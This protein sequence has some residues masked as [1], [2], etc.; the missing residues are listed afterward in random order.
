ME[1]LVFDIN[2]AAKIDNI[3]QN[4]MIKQLN[5]SDFLAYDKDYLSNPVDSNFNIIKAFEGTEKQYAQ[6]ELAIK[7]QHMSR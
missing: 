3:K 5:E 1:N 6:L 2:Y 4:L 7:K